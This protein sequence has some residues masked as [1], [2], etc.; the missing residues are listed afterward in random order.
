M[1][2]IECAVFDVDGTLLN[3][4][5]H[6]VQAFEIVL[7]GFGVSPDREN[8]RKVIGKKLL[9]CYKDLVPEGDHDAMARAHHEAQQT[10]EMYD[11][12]TIYDGLRE[13]CEE[14]EA[15]GVKTAIQTN[16]GRESIDLIF[17]HLQ[18]SDVFDTIV[19]PEDVQEPKPADDGIQVIS[20]RLQISPS[21]MV[22]IGDTPIDVQTAMNAG[23]AGSIGIL[24][25]FGTE[26]ELKDA[27]ATV[28]I[29]GLDKLPEAVRIFSN[30]S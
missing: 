14:L 12:I 25:G 18:I 1:S 11:L 24:H 17:N 6:I 4:F 29:D 27:G 13:S 19:T 15:T 22:M 20:R 3:T 7:P 26:Q 30:E 21:Q 8:I 9:D 23:M 2:K 16:R 10:P 28:L 5:E